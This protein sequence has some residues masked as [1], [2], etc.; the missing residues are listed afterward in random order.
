[1]SKKQVE[2]TR[3]VSRHRRFLEDRAEVELQAQARLREDAQN[4]LQESEF[5]LNA[6]SQW[7]ESARRPDGVDL[8]LYQNALHFEAVGVQAVE[9]VG[10]ALDNAR[11]GEQAALSQHVLARNATRVTRS[12]LQR[13]A[14]AWRV[15]QEH[16]LSDQVADLWL[17]YKDSEK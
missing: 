9:A 4:V 13:V 6:V 17:A 1:M 16:V 7:K 5:R 14:E 10:Q 12:R 11:N 8:T 2:R 15:H 3:K